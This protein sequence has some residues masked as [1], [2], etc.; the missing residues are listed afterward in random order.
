MK[1]SIT[2][3]SYSSYFTI[4]KRV[5]TYPTLIMKTI[6]PNF[7]LHSFAHFFS[8]FHRRIPALFGDT[9]IFLMSFRK[10]FFSHS[11]FHFF[12][13][14]VNSARHFIY[15]LILLILILVL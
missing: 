5:L 1:S 9:N 12:S 14:L 3:F 10:Y 4:I 7:S 15:F 8:S 13:S 6:L 2:R 11:F